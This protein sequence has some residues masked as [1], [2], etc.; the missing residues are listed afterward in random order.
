MFEIL[1]PSTADYDPGRNLFFYMQIKTLREYYAID[2]S[3]KH[4]RVGRRRENNAWQFEEISVE[5]GFFSIETIDLKLMLDDM[6]R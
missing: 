2:S 5:G 4:I 3:S 6:R 1:S